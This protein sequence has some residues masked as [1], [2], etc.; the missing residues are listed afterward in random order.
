MRTSRYVIVGAGL[1]GA[2]AAKA[3]RSTDPEGSIALIGNESHPPCNRP[4]L[5]KAFLRGEKQ[6]EEAFVEPTDQYTKSNIKLLLQSTVTLAGKQ[7]TYD[8]VTY[9]WSDIFDLQLE[10]SGWSKAADTTRLRG[11]PGDR[12]G[13]IV[14][15]LKNRALKVY[16]AVNAPKDA[17]QPLETLIRSR[18]GESHH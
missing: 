11:K 6:P 4:P 13:F 3:I 5:S 10:F 16:L 2:E 9:N 8:L 7:E 17:Y 12:D 14:L 18:A 1:A 15:Y